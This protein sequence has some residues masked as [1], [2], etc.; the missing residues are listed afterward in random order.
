MLN[1]TI[2]P[3]IKDARDFNLQLPLYR[4]QVLSNG[5][6]V[7]AI[8]LGNEEAMMISWIFDAGNWHEKKNGVAAAVSA[9]LKN[10]TSRRTAF[11]I[12]EHFEYYGAFLSRASHHETAD[13]TLHCLTRHLPELLPVIAELIADSTFPEEE[14]SIYKKNAS[15]RLQVN[16][17]K[18]DFVA[19]R[20]IESYLYGF[21]HPYG[22]YSMLEDF[23]HFGR[24]DLLQFYERH[25]RQGACRILVAGKLPASLSQDMERYFGGMP[26][27]APVAQDPSTWPAIRPAAEKK[28]NVVNDPDGVQGSIRMARNFPN[29]HHPDFQKV[30]VL[31]NVFGGFFGSRLMTNIREDKGYTYGIYSYLMNLRQESALMITT[32]AGKEVCRA[33]IEEVYKEMELLREELIDEEELAMARNFAIGTILGDLDGPFQVA[34]RWKNLILNGLNEQYFYEG[35]RIVKSIT[36]EELR[37]L[38]RKYLDPEAFF[39]LVVV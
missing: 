38:A 18:S 25:Y 21:D 23:Q 17:K 4:K 26:L 14:L 22:R 28:Y 12:S 29:R 2:A 30:Q 15:Q 5:V 39:E 6:E 7:Y 20:L 3:P 34:S 10:G 19:G 1:R 24:E 35:I 32:E 33:T 16:L 36:P 11:Q 31:N 37:E 9:L 8:D 27:H 13:V